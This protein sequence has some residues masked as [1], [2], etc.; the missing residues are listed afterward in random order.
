M[1]IER[2][3]FPPRADNADSL[4]P[5]PAIDHPADETPIG[6][7]PEPIQEPMPSATIVEFPAQ[8]K[9]HP[10]KRK[11]AVAGVKHCGLELVPVKKNKKKAKGKK[12]EIAFRK[13]CA[14]VEFKPW[15][16][17]DK[18]LVAFGEH[19]N[20]TIGV[21]VRVGY[22]LMLMSKKDMIEFHR[23]M[24]QDQVD[25]VFANTLEAAEFLKYTAAMLE[26]VYARLLT[27]AYA[28][29]EQGII[30]D[31]KQPIRF[32]GF[33]ARPMLVRQR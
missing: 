14:E 21:S 4:I 19:W 25:I 30:G 18:D 8:P 1:T 6:D 24:D 11:S 23:D 2:P 31:G 5:Q 28:A 32:E 7:S 12:D 3:M 17:R 20:S 16:K 22:A 27:S 29:L 9:K 13:Y 15:K 10:A 33:E 26:T